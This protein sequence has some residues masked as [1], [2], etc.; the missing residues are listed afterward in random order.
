MTS[1][2]KMA[3]YAGGGIVA[4][5]VVAYVFSRQSSGT[6]QNVTV[7]PPVLPPQNPAPSGIPIGTSGTVSGAGGVSTAG[8]NTNAGPPIVPPPGGT[9]VQNNT[10]NQQQGNPFGQ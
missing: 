1:N 7:T 9:T 4:L 3:L 8:G 10:N 6:A 2:Q 5:G